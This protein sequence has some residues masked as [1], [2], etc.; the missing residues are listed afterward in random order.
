MRAEPK[1]AVILFPGTNC[2]LETIRAC[3]RA[4]MI[5]ILFRWNDDRT[6]LK[7]FDA[8][9]IPG[10]F[11]YED[12]GRSGIVAAKD[13]ILDG[14]AKE[15]FKG[16]PILGICNG[17]QILVEK[18]LIPGIHPQMLEMGLAYNRRIIKDKILGTGFWNDWIYIRSEKSTLKTPYNRFS[19]ETI[20]RIPVA[21][22]EGR[23]VVSGKLLL[24]QLI[25]NGQTLFRYCDKNGKFIEQFPVNPNGAAYNLAGVCNPEGNILALMPH[26]E[27]TLSG[28]PIFD[29]LADYL[30]KSGRRITV[31]KAKPAVTNIQHE[32]PA[33]QTKKPDIEITVELII[34]DNEERTIENAIRKMGFK[35]ISLA[36][37]TYFGIF[38]KS[39][40]DLLKIADKIIRS[41]ELL[42]LNKEI[43][44]IRI[45]NK[46]YGYDRIS[47]IH[48]IKEKNTVEPQF[49]VM[50]KENYAGKSMKVRLQPYFP[51]GEIINLEKGVLWRVKAKKEKEIQNILDTHIFH[52]PNAMKI[53]A[54]K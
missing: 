35:N 7:N 26:P 6:K 39:N 24:E 40:K 43:P 18:G 30:T 52:N 38:A 14:L 9:I 5:P 11:S 8:F 51:G 16:K 2:E 48:Q 49:L 20:M 37:K 32:K 25:K 13:P 29:S 17:A 1:L 27:R 10:G 33:H 34:T 15:A 23:F 54:I 53:M 42:N 22:G 36:K 45:N 21:N 47:G 50:D 28:Q 12:R 19:P 3:K 41:G 31:S 44:F 4:K 46:F